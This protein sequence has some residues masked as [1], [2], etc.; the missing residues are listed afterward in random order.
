MLDIR[1]NE[2]DMNLDIA[3]EGVDQRLGTFGGSELT[4]QRQSLLLLRACSCLYD[5]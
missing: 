1:S 3:K 2:E 5:K 4:G